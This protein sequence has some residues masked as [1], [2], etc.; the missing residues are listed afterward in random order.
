MR[1]ISAFCL[2][3]LAIVGCGRHKPTSSELSPEFDS[4]TNPNASH[5][6][7]ADAGGSGNTACDPDCEGPVAMEGPPE[8]RDARIDP[9][10]GTPLSLTPSENTGLKQSLKE[11]PLAGP[12]GSAHIHV[13]AVNGQLVFSSDKVQDATH[14]TSD[15]PV[16]FIGTPNTSKASVPVRLVATP[17][18]QKLLQ[19]RMHS[20]TP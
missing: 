2:V 20:S 8:M 6:A 19:Q 9:A 3:V 4:S 18:A 10:K 1:R 5:T 12:A 7:N 14:V 13:D 15:D 17:A 11:T 16:I